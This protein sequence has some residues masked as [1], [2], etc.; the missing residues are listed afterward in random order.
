MS[1]KALSYHAFEGSDRNNLAMES[2]A[3]YDIVEKHC[4]G[5][6]KRKST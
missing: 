1:K 4:R 6:G 2:D 3:C 5:I